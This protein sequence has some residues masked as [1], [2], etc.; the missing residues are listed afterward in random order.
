[1]KQLIVNES[2]DDTGVKKVSTANFNAD[3]IEILLRT[4]LLM[5]EE[6]QFT[7]AAQGFENFKKSL[8]FIVDDSKASFPRW[9]MEPDVYAVLIEIHENFCKLAEGLSA[10]YDHVTDVDHAQRKSPSDTVKKD[11]EPLVRAKSDV[12]EKKCF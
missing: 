9:G 4:L 12:A 11:A 3:T 6:H 10:T 5:K 7:S 1:M 8:D 2:A